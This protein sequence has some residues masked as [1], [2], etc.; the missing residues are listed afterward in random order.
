MLLLCLKCIDSG[1]DMYILADAS[2]VEI[3]NVI[4]SVGFF[5][6]IVNK[7]ESSTE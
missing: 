6:I 5:E 4:C 3:S 7:I 2:C 1:L